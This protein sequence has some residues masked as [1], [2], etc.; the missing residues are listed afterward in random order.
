MSTLPKAVLD[1]QAKVVDSTK[2]LS[3][4]KGVLVSFLLRM[5]I[6]LCRQNLT[7]LLGLHLLDLVRL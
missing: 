5:R 2:S 3:H 7:E 1:I 6:C 4:V